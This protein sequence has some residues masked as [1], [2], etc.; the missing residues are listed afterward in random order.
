MSEE[1]TASVLIGLYF[2]LEVQLKLV[3]SARLR[4]TALD[5]F[6]PDMEGAGG[7]ARVEDVVEALEGDD[8]LHDFDCALGASEDAAGVRAFDQ[9]ANRVTGAPKAP[10]APVIILPERADS[11]VGGNR[12]RDES[13]VEP[14]EEV[15]GVV[16][17]DDEPVRVFTGVKGA[18]GKYRNCGVV[19]AAP[20]IDG[21][22]DRVCTVVA[23]ESGAGARP[24][25]RELSL[26]GTDIALCDIGGT[27]A[28]SARV[29]LSSYTDDV[30]LTVAHPV[31]VAGATRLCEQRVELLA[32]AARVWTCVLAAKRIGTVTSPLSAHVTRI[33]RVCSER[34]A[35]AA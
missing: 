4:G 30:V 1:A 20:E 7:R 19:G 5:R 31:T 24:A 12:G 21:M 35:S 23:H 22:L 27:V 29:S 14:I 13:W 3:G 16:D 34:N 33:S 10:L 6:D 8:V 15:V 28:G 11:A 25:S 2:G 32:S 18:F 17:I 26:A 9:A